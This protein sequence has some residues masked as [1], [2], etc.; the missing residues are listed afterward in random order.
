[1]KN[2]NENWSSIDR[3]VGPTLGLGP[4]NDGGDYGLVDEHARI[5]GE[6]IHQ[7]AENETR[8]ALANATLWAAALPL[9]RALRA[10][11]DS[12]LAL[13][14]VDDVEDEVVTAAEEALRAATMEN[15]N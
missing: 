15:E 11:L 4:C 8:D 14:D 2:K 6:A 1:M 10:L 5:V 7:V 9:Y 13:V 12:Y 3:I